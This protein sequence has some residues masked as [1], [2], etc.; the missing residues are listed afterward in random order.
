MFSTANIIKTNACKHRQVV[1]QSPHALSSPWL[2]YENMARVKRFVDSV[3]YTGPLTIGG[4]CTKVRA[5]LAFSTD[6]GS[7]ILGSILPLNECEV[8]EPEEIDTVIAK[9]KR[10]KGIATQTRAVIVKV[11]RH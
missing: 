2:V 10:K 6:Y 1:K 11:N 7:H 4:D 8:D 9:I 5:R 3:G